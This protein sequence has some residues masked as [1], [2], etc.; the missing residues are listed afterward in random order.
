MTL[1]LTSKIP[2][3]STSYIAY[4]VKCLDVGWISQFQFLEGLCVQTGS[5]VH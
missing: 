3:A 5:E 2:V 4:V 1:H